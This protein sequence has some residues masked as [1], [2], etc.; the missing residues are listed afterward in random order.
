M[1]PRWAY[2][3]K[4]GWVAAGAA[5]AGRR[6]SGRRVGGGRESPGVGAHDGDEGGE[7]G[8]GDGGDEEGEEDDGKWLDDG[9]DGE[10]ALC[11]VVEGIGV[12]PQMPVQIEAAIRETR[13]SFFRP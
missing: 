10:R 8:D 3:A 2:Q 4:R 11:R 6:R 9:G 7:E 13:V 5:T 1:P 12:Q